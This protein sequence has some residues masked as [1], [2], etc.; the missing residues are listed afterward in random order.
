[1]IFMSNKILL[2]L[3]NE[4]IHVSPE[5]YECLKRYKNPT[6]LISSIIIKLKRNI[7]TKNEFLIVTKDLIEN[8]AKQEGI[9][10][11]KIAME[12]NE[13]KTIKNEIANQK[14]KI[15]PKKESRNKEKSNDIDP[16]LESLIQ[17]E[18]KK[19]F[20]NNP[21]DNIPKEKVSE[22]ELIPKQTSIN[23]PK[24]IELEVEKVDFNKHDKNG[25]KIKRNFGTFS[26]DDY[27]FKVL[28]DTSNQSYTSG[29][30]KDLKS[31]F[32]NRYEKLKNI[33][34]KRPELN[35]SMAINDLSQ[36]KDETSIIAMISEIRDTKNNHVI[37]E[38]ED[39]T[40]TTNVLIHSDNK[41]LI[42]KSKVLVKDQVIGINGIYKGTLFIANEII[43]PG[44][45]RVNQKEMDF[46]I[47]F[48]SDVHIGSKTFLGESFGNFISWLNGNFGNEEQMNIANDVKYLV[49][50][51]DLVD[52]IGIYPNQEEELEIMDITQQYDE[53][54]RFLGDLRT[55][56]K[57]ILGPGNHDA[58]RIAEPQPAVPKEYAK[59]LYDLKNI[60][61]ISNPGI[62]SLEGLNLLMYHGRSFDDIAMN[63]N[64]YGHDRTDL[65]MKELL[66]KRHLAPI[67]GERTSLA[68]ELEDHLVID[69]IP[70]I[71]H[72]GHVHINAYKNYKGIHLINSGTFQTQTEFQKIYNIIPTVAEV[73]ILNKGAIKTLKFV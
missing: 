47:A 45:P 36:A 55:D 61:C 24:K 18:I 73:P 64:G 41:E 16:G 25:D 30:I 3:T 68:S 31:Y 20:S 27:N 26:E 8:I 42:E 6:N 71:F 60:E 11:E 72:T 22:D 1:M 2:K 58:S 56:I 53:A 67:Y 10:D 46:S 29:T 5:A 39:D 4:G 9:S 48:I 35:K 65:I 17:S 14:S 34:V 19:E 7:K 38:V 37:M 63:I 28:Q 62:V 40:A 69:Q 57:I 70:D 49:I 66:E 50:S 32:L 15:T 51:G 44:V 13:L 21:V 43:Q 59:S 33:L 54:A 23:L 12:E 52:G